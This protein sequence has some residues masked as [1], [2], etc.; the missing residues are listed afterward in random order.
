MELVPP[1]DIAV[2]CSAA[3]VFASDQYV[4]YPLVPVISVIADVAFPF[5]IPVRVVAPVPP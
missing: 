2:Y 3:I 4:L 1:L 5:N